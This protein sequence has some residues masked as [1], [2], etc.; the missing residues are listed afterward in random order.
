VTRAD[1]SASLL[2]A[3]FVLW[4]PAAALPARIW[5]APP[6]ERLALVSRQRRR[7]Q[8]VNVAIMVATV[9]LV[10]G[11]TGLAEPLRQN[12]AATLADFSVALL[13]LGAPLWLA[14]LVHRVVVAAD[15]ADWAGGLFLAWS[16]LANTALIGFGA[17]LVRSDLPGGWSGWVGIVLGALILA[18]LAWTGDALPALYHLG[19]A[20]TGVAL[21]LS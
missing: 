3:S 19:P 21:L 8:L 2:V 6:A 12:G 13:L 7:W 4:F 17:A 9:L 1:V 11:C 14:T 15:G 10:L 20:V 5:T 16:T 18:Q